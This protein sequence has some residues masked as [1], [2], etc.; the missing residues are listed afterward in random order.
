VSA[1]GF[2]LLG[3]KSGET[4]FSADW[5]FCLLKLMLSRGNLIVTCV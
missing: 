4:D 5:V 3:R 2:H 1:G